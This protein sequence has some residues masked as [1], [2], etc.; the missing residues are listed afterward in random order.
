M[1]LRDGTEA[2]SA[3]DPQGG[4]SA[5]DNARREELRR[6]R[7]RFRRREALIFLAF[8]IPNLTLIALFTYRPLFSNVYYSLLQWNMGSPTARFVGLDNYVNW[9]SDPHSWNYLRI[10]IIFTVA[11]VGGTIVIGLL[12]AT[13][14]NQK[15]H[16]RGFARAVVF[17]PYVLSGVAVGL[18]W[19]FMFDPQFGVIAPLI[20]A[21]G[22]SPPNWYNSPGW[23]L[24][25][26]IIVYIWKHLGYA[27]VVYL[28]GLQIIPRDLLEAAAIDGAGRW[29]TFRSITLPLLSPMTF[30]LLV[31]VTLSSMSMQSFELIH[32]MTRGGPVDGTTT[33]MYQIYREGFVTGRAGYSATVATIL[34]VILLGVTLLQMRFLERKVHYS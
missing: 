7:R 5:A 14:L 8:T 31:T 16:G 32:S 19:M 22:A 27:A 13:V 12:V 15:L 30:F 10:T 1:A 21:V 33:L 4:T 20:R 34:F 3:A 29:R 6:G 18:V 23:A 28:A 2:T 26:V 11:T 24:V 25:M 17:A 9:F